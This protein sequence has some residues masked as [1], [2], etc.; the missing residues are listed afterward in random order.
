MTTRTISLFGLIGALGATLALAAL[1]P[2]PAHA[3]GGFFCNSAQPVNQSAERIIFSQGDDGTVT[4]VI[5]IQ[6]AGPSERF[7]WVLPVTGTPEVGVSSNA[8][9]SRLQSQTNPFYQL[10]TTI[11]GTCADSGFR[12]GPSSGGADAGAAV[13]DGGESPPPVTVVDSGAVGPYDYVVISVDPSALDTADVAVEWLGDNGYDVGSLGGDVL[14]PYLDAGMNLLAFRLTKGNDAGSIRPVRITFGSGLPSIPI[15][16]TAVAAND[17]MGIMVWVLGA[18][19]AIPAN[20]LSLE[21]ND[22]LINWINPSLNYDDVVT[23][24]ANEAGGQGF[25]TEMAGA[26]APL[27]EGIYSSYE[28]ESWRST[29]STDWTNREG[30]LLAN[31]TGTYGYWD[32]MRD[33]IEATLPT[34]SGVTVDELL[35]CVSCYYPWDTADIAG[36]DPSAFLASVEENVIAPMEETAALF[37]DRPYV[38]RFY[39]T[40]SAHEMTMDPLF[41]FNGELGDVS[42]THTADRVV[43]C[44]PRVTQADAPWVVELEGG[45]VY[46]RGSTWPFDTADE[47]MPANRRVLRVG[48]TGSGEVVV[49]NGEQI[50]GALAALEDSV[51]VDRGLCSVSFTESAAP[52]G[53]LAVLGALFAVTR[54]RRRRGHARRGRRS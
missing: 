30:E 35:S 9:F 43:Y 15:R 54:R 48:T 21:L 32:G 49:D 50:A 34:P 25:V 26:T 45:S 1:S 47:D 52:L 42:N 33:V 23:R 14:R 4:A 37:T 27:A 36:F 38:T 10:N 7:A 20:Y 16:P 8:A 13:L 44:S 24:A 5:Q 18:H 46:G 3:C 28:R 12:G 22:A 6:Y 2:A 41:D 51:H 11:L 40:M 17:D 31:V 53:A 39:T 19:R 29:A